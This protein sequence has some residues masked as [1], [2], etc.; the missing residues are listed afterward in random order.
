MIE[1]K[2]HGLF[3]TRVHLFWGRDSNRW[4][5]EWQVFRNSFHGRVCFSLLRR[6]S[7]GLGMRDEPKERLRRRLGLLQLLCMNI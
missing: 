7:L 2:G 4:S 5:N 1:F 6:R 3:Q